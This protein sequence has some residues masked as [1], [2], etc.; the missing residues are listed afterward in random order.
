MDRRYTLLWAGPTIKVTLIR[1]VHRTN[2]V[3][4][5]RLKLQSRESA[6]EGHLK[7]SATRKMTKVK[8]RERCRS[9][10]DHQI[11]RSTFEWILF[12]SIFLADHI[13]YMF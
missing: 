10:I 8:P 9:K 2:R 4:K 1:T 6:N 7:N 3:W 11:K 5:T 13:L 12:H